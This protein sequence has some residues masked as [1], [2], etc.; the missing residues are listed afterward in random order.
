[1]SN[2]KFLLHLQFLPKTIL[3]KI[4]LPK[5]ILAK[6]VRFNPGEQ[7]ASVL[8]RLPKTLQWKL[9]GCHRSLLRVVRNPLGALGVDEE[10]G[11]G[12]VAAANKP[13]RRL[14]LQRP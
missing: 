2:R 9:S 8:A 12:E 6:I 11:D 13:W 14:L 5:T 4:M 7:R 1:M 10:V 3:S